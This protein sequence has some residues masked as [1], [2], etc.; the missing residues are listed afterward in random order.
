MEA[1]SMPDDQLMSIKDLASYLNVNVTTIYLW[2]NRG[3]IPAIKVGN[4]WRYRRSDIE[5]WLNGQRNQPV[6]QEAATPGT[7]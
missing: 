2:S 5:D 3:Q 4:L 6:K 7:K 1:L